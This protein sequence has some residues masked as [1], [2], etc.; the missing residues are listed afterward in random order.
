MPERCVPSGS[1]AN[2]RNAPMMSIKGSSA[3]LAPPAEQVMTAMNGRLQDRGAAEPAGPLEVHWVAGLNEQGRP[4][5]W[6]GSWLEGPEGHEG[7]WFFSGAGGTVTEHRPPHG[8][9]GVRIRRWPS[10]GLDPEYVDLPLAGLHLLLTERLDFDAPAARR[11]WLAT[12]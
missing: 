10:D 7:G 1:Y 4:M 3:G 8:A 6:F 11:D 12:T 9:T 5:L 2:R